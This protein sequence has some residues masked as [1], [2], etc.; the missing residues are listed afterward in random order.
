MDLMKGFYHNL[1]IATNNPAKVEFKTSIHDAVKAV[2]EHCVK[3]LEEDVLYTLPHEITIHLIGQTDTNQIEFMVMA[4]IAGI[5]LFSK[6]FTTGADWGNIT[7]TPFA[8]D[9]YHSDVMRAAVDILMNLKVTE[10]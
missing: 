6:G 7:I 2:F 8:G 1:K 9:Y 10:Q 3:E 5:R 4:E